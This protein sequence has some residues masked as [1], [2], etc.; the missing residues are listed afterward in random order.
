MSLFRCWGEAEVS[1][2]EG[3]SFGIPLRLNNTDSHDLQF[4]AFRQRSKLT[5]ATHSGT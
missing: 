5:L 2:H 1:K 4:D 3:D